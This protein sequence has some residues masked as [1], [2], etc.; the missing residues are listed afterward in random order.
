VGA[1]SAAWQAFSMAM[2]RPGAQRWFCRCLHPLQ[3]AIHGYGLFE[4]R[5]N[6]AK[7]AFLG[8]GGLERKNAF[9]GFANFI[10]ANTEGDGIFLAHGPA[11]Q[12]QAQLI[13]EKFLENE[14][15]LGGE[16]KRLSASRDSPRRE[17][18]VD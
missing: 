17:M 10:F 1:I 18:S 9:Q 3:E 14:A 15:L 7:N 6:L 16:R 12:G 13:Q 5:G 8:V 11:A 4:V 2:T